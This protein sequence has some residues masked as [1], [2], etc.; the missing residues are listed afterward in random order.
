MTAATHI[1]KPSAQ[2]RKDASKGYACTHTCIYI[3]IHVKPIQ[4]MSIIIIII[5][6]I[7]I[8]I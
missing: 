3:A 7:I 4:T 6:I 5:I 8:K 2:N 1:C